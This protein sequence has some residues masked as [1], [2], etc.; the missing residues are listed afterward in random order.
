MS[1]NTTRRSSIFEATSPAVATQTQSQVL[2]GSVIQTNQDH[3]PVAQTENRSVAISANL[4]SEEKI[5]ALGNA[6]GSTITDITS[7]LLEN[8]R[9]NDT[10]GLSSKLNSLIA[11]A[12]QL[13]PEST[14][15]N[16]I[17][18]FFKKIVGV[19]E[20]F[21]AQF[22]TVNGRIQ[23]LCTELGNER[24]H[25]VLRKGDVEN[26][27]KANKEYGQSMHNDF[28]AGQVYLAEIGQ[29]VDRLA[30]PSTTDEAQLLSE[31]KA[32]YDMLEKKLAD[33]QGLRLMSVQMNDKL[34]DMKTNAL[35]LISTFD[36]IIG[37][38][39][40]AYTM[41]FSQYLISIDQERAGK[42]QNATVDAFNEALQ[43]GSDLNMKNKEEAALLRNRQLVSIE[44]LKHDHENM[45]KGI[46]SVKRIDEQERTKRISYVQDIRA[47]EQKLI[48]VHQSK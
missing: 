25:Q 44:T 9:A 10:E 47:M 38:V 45:L 1:E 23:V 19:K 7:K 6:A 17:T 12:K 33:L 39:V 28:E 29:E 11:E 41:V 27:I 37:K 8:Q 4:I 21:F 26:L 30:N 22:D 32:R 46:E 31:V 48:E 5:S 20:N 18:G 3:L 35:S 24:Q 40:P 2:T 42:L 16:G 43:K 15:Q 13:D 36:D 34:V 14:K